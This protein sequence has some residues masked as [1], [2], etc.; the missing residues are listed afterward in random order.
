MFP[1]KPDFKP[2]TSNETRQ[3]LFGPMKYISAPIKGNLENISV[4]GS[5]ARD[6]L[7]IIEVPQLAGIAGAPNSRKIQFHIKAADAIRFLFLELEQLGLLDNIHSWDGA[8]CP[9]FVRGSKTILS[10][11]AFGTAFDINASWNPIGSAPAIEGKLG[12]LYDIVPIANKHSFYWG[13]HYT[14]RPDG[15]HFEYSYTG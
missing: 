12:C 10:N 14:K 11:H 6:N 15:M 8:Y 2:L 1:N 13:G 7:C 9:R 3:E 5:W 4:Q